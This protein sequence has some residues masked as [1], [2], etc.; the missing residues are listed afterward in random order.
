MLLRKIYSSKGYNK[1]LILN[2]ISNMA[3][4]EMSPSTQSGITKD[5]VAHN[6]GFKGLCTNFKVLVPD[7]SPWRGKTIVV[8]TATLRHPTDTHTNQG[9]RDR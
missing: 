7:T 8:V 4:W 3:H 1:V 6:N 5:A 9:G 2:W